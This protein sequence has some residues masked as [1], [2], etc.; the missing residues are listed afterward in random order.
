MK[1]LCVLLPFLV[2]FAFA[3]GDDLNPLSDEFIKI[4]NEKATTWKVG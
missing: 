3:D 2:D 4:V 1:F